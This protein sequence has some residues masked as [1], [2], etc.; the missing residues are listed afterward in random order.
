MSDSASPLMLRRRLRTELRTARLSKELT[1]EQVAKAMEWSL[2][3]MNRIEKAK[4]SISINDLRVL[5]PLYDITNKKRTDEL[6]AMAQGARRPGWWSGFRNVA[7]PELLTLIEYESAASVISQFE[8]MFVPGILQTKEYAE[9]VL[10][11][12]HAEESSAEKVAALVDLRTRL[13]RLLTGENAA[14]RSFILD[15]SVIHRLVGSPSIMSHQLM[16]LV[17]VAELSNVT[18]QVVPF[19]AGQHPGMK[20]PFEV[21]QFDDAPDESIVFFEGLSGDSIIEDP[22]EVEKYLEVFNRITGIALEPPD[23][24]RRILEAAKALDMTGKSP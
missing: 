17:S 8:T 10:Q 19:T 16:H 4:S 15:E 21:V 2:S 9:A 13:R 12:F 7:S 22:E 3:K 6:V 14:K 5:L 20:G 11:V 23:S 1:Q 18:I 24:V